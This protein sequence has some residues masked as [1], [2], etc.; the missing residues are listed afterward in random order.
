MDELPY[1]DKEKCELCNNGIIKEVTRRIEDDRVSVGRAAKDMASDIEALIGYPL[2][3]WVSIRD[4]YNYNSGKRKQFKNDKEK[5]KADAQLKMGL[6]RM[7]FHREDKPWLDVCDRRD[8]AIK[9]LK[10]ES[11]TELGNDKQWPVFLVNLIKQTF[12]EKYKL[13]H[14]G[15]PKEYQRFLTHIEA[16]KESNPKSPQEKGFKKW[17]KDQMKIHY[18]SAKD[19]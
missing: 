18:P 12:E 2:V 3:T 5:N 4:R 19:K 6:G 14:G 10:L 16:L 9:F 11:L 13:E 8:K 17:R 15:S 1:F 7:F